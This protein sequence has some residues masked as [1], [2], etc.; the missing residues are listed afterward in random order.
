MLKTS[1]FNKPF[2]GYCAKKIEAIPVYRP[3]DS[4][5]LGKGKL[6]FKNQTTLVGED[7]QFLTPQCSNKTIDR[8]EMKF[9]DC[10]ISIF[11][12]FELKRDQKT[13][14]SDESNKESLSLTV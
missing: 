12:R 2:V 7:A 10:S 11:S 6:R 3:E 9:E 13:V 4:K 14:F 8:S 1:S 5:I